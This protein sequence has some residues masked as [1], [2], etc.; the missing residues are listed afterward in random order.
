MDL[1]TDELPPHSVRH[2]LDA[3]GI[4]NACSHVFHYECLVNWTTTRSNSCLLCNPA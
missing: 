1:I 3:L 4:P 2:T